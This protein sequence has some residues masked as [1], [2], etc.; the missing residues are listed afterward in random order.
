MQPAIVIENL[1]KCYRVARADAPA[2]YT[3]L[4]ESLVHA[5]KWPLRRIRGG[6]GARQEPF[7]ALKDINLTVEPGETVGI[8]G[9]NGAGKSTLLK[10]LS[11]ITKPTGGQA[12]LRGRVG[13]LLEVGT[14][15][16]PELTG[17]ENI[18]LNGSI[19]GMARREIAAKF[20]EIVSFAEVEQ[21]LDIPVKRYS[22]GMYTRLAF[23]VAAHLEPEILVI[24]EVLAVGDAEFQKKCMK[25]M[26]DVANEGRTVLFVSHNMGAIQTVCRRV[27]LLRDGKVQTI[28][29]VPEVVAE[30]L[31]VNDSTESAA[32]AVR[33]DRTGDGRFRF[34]EFRLFDAQGAPSPFVVTGED[35]YFSIRLKTPPLEAAMPWPLDVAVIIRDFQGMKLTEVTTHFTGSSP[36]TH[37]ASRLLSVLVPR[38]PLL[39]GQYRVD[40]WCGT[41]GE[42][43]DWI[44]DALILRVEQGNYFRNFSDA[45]LPTAERQGCIMIP[46]QWHAPIPTSSRGQS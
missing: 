46:Q 33:R 8:I 21:F 44:T 22:S 36:R 27:V 10:I 11:R 13:S 35:A 2:D 34:E 1:S 43:Q 18:Y 7:W 23:A 25:K 9:R 39:A 38:L 40:L 28:G 12:R 31:K 20:D 37:A 4:R 3:T 17:R 30:Y 41:S 24:D 14:G 5:A 42:T 16:H 26:G 15:F 29:S 45:R 19:L 6:D 32:L